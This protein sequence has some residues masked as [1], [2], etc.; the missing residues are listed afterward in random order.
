MVLVEMQVAKRVNE[1]ARPKIANLRDHHGE[2][3]VGGDVEGHAE[4]QIGAPL[5]KLAAELAGGDVELEE[6]M[7]G[8][9]R[10]LLQL[11]DVPGAHDQAPALRVPFN[12][13]DYVV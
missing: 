2:Q 7:A 10:H 6:H 12:V 13:G 8:R 1:F 3:G 5:I 9:Q 11:A 4:K